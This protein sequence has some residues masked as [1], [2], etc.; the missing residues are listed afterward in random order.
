MEHYRKQGFPENYGLAA[1][2][3][4]IRRK[5][6]ELEKLMESWWEELNTFS[7]RDQLSL[8]YVI[9]KTGF[10][11]YRLFNYY[12]YKKSFTNTKHLG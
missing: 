1:N 6:E 8:F 10:K 2:R 11:K 5:S 7:R 12:A 3:I 4:I 9:W